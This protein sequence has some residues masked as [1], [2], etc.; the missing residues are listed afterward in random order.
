MM[1]I[2][3]QWMRRSML[4]IVLPVLLLPALAYSA[5]AVTEV[6]LRVALLFNFMRFTE[7]PN[8]AL[9]ADGV[10]VTVCIARGDAEMKEALSVLETRTIREHPIAVRQISRPREVNACHI[11]YLPDSLPGRM[12]DYTDAAQ[13]GRTLTIS[14][15][16]GFID[17]NGMIGL[18]LAGG[19]YRFEV[20]NEAVRRAELRLHPQLL[21]LAAR[22]R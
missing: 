13:P 3:I 22:V 8:G 12:S 11:L 21:N 5:P 10:P 19:R 2:I 20:N 9:G 16:A 14:N 6:E 4:G 7:W 18:K 1:P 17:N 15:H